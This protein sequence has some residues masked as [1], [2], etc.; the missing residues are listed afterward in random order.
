VFLFVSIKVLFFSTEHFDQIT[1][2]VY[3]D[4]L[5]LKLAR[6]SELEEEVVEARLMSEAPP[7]TTYNIWTQG[8]NARR[9]ASFVLDQGPIGS[10]TANAMSY[11]W[12]LYSYKQW[13]SSQIPPSPPSRMFWYAEARMHLN[14]MD[15]YPNAPLQDTGCYVEDIAWVPGTKGQLPE[16]Q[17]PYTFSTDRRGNVVSTSGNVNKFPPAAITTLALASLLPPDTITQ[18]KYSVNPSTTLLNMKRALSSNRTIL[19]GIYVYTS[20]VSSTALRTG[21]IPIPVRQRERLLGGHC[22][23]LTGYDTTCFTFRNSWGKNVGVQGAFRIPFSYIT[24]TS[25]SGDAWLF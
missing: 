6:D 7:P 17:Y 16:T 12:M 23:C 10:C 15:G 3:L 2:T 24:N 4:P 20:F 25:L 19:L 5:R 22:I 13:N 1:T 11:A 8:P 14:A 21:N 9:L 18:F